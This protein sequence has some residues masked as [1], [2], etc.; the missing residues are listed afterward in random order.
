M[1]DMI[2]SFEDR[3][4]LDIAIAGFRARRRDAESD[5]PPGIGWRQASLHGHMQC[6]HRADGMIGRPHPQH[7]PGPAAVQQTGSA[8]C[9]ESA[10]QCV[11]SSVVSVY[12]NKK[13]T[14]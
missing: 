9:R 3:A 12:L 13:K 2:G 1:A 7:R 11:W 5:Q 6:L 4:D 14:T 10:C 8:S